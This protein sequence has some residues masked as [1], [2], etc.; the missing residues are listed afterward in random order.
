MQRPAAVPLGRTN[1]WIE[2]KGN[3]AAHDCGHSRANDVDVSHDARGA[4]VMSYKGCATRQSFPVDPGVSA[5]G[6][7]DLVFVTSR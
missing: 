2:S 3:S 5:E 4:K 6:I 7:V 1:G